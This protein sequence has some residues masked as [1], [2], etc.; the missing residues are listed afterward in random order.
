MKL[1]LTVKSKAGHSDKTLKWHLIDLA[2]KALP[3]EVAKSLREMGRAT[4]ED[5]WIEAEYA[6]EDEPKPNPKP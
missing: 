2:C 4:Y 3:A 5:D 1:S 6:L